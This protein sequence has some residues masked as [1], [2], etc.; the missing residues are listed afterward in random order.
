MV[1]KLADAAFGMWRLTLKQSKSSLNVAGHPNPSSAEHRAWPASGY[2][3][4]DPLAA[5][6]TPQQPSSLQGC[7]QMPANKL[8][9]HQASA[10]RAFQLDHS[11]MPP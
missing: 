5:L 2:N 8:Q 10:H 6:A 1:D 9:R 11:T 3:P 7:P 4:D